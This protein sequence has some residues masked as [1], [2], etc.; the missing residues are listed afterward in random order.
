MGGGGG[1]G[2][3]KKFWVENLYKYANLSIYVKQACIPKMKSLK[4]FHV[5]KHPP[6]TWG[7][8]GGVE[9][10]LSLESI[11]TCKNKLVYQK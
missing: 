2:G 10:I 1:G 6:P 8:E 11:Y 7:G 4:L 5:A 3:V 9:K